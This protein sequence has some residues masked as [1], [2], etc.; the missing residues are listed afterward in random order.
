MD[1]KDLKKT[2]GEQIVIF[3]IVNIIRCII[4]GC[5]NL[6]FCWIPLVVIVLFNLII[7]Q[8]LQKAVENP[9]SMFVLSYLISF[10]FLFYLLVIKKEKVNENKV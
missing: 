3:V 10:I 2:K 5:F 8:S 4:I 6:L 1:A 7:T 9:F